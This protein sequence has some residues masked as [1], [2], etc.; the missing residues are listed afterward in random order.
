[1]KNSNI[2]LDLVLVPARTLERVVAAKLP[3]SVLT[4]YESL[5]GIL[6]TEE[7]YFYKHVNENISKHVPNA[8]CQVF[9]TGSN[10]TGTSL[11]TQID[12]V[13]T[14]MYMTTLTST[15]V[16]LTELLVTCEKAS[17]LQSTQIEGNNYVG[18]YFAI[19]ER[20]IGVV[21]T[22][23]DSACNNV[24]SSV[25]NLLSLLNSDYLIDL[26]HQSI[27]RNKN[28]GIRVLSEYGLLAYY[29][30]ILTTDKEN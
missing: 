15:E 30:S 5:H 25:R 10:C 28:T 11:F 13:A 23:A 27:Y 6:N 19:D 2:N 17:L 9:A 21:F 3:L 8:V 20:T 4:S 14:N 7:L 18:Q 24:R 22:V 16:D 12:D 26:N 1:M 29:C